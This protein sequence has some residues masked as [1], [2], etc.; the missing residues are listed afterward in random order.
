M[1]GQ[2][3]DIV[4]GN[5]LEQL[6]LFSEYELV[7]D[8]TELIG[9]YSFDLERFDPGFIQ[10]IR[11]YAGGEELWAL[12]NNMTRYALHYNKEIF[13]LFG[14][15]YPEEGM[16]WQEVISLASQ[17]SG[18][19]G[20][21]DYMGLA[22]P[23]TRIL[24]STMEVPLVDP[25]TDKP[26]FTEEPIFQEFFRLYEQVYH[27][28]NAEPVT[29]AV[30]KFVTDRTLAMMPI[31]FL[32]SDWTGIKVATDEGMAGIWLFFRFGTKGMLLR[33]WSVDNGLRLPRP[34]SR[35]TLHLKLLCF[36]KIPSKL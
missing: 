32:W 4:F 36:C 7:T 24:L 23:A 28:P 3:P 25:E 14:V 26:L 6:Y 18:E 22:L 17:V 13:D 1:A 20:G 2:V 34:V 5:N 10:A 8:H 27:L 30:G 12:P 35:K 33:L 9:K 29:Q 16:T 31:F 15:D 21:Q 11:S 19:R